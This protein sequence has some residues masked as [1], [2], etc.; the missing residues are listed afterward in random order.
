MY[1][2]INAV[3]LAKEIRA[4]NLRETL[5][6]IARQVF[7]LWKSAL[8]KVAYSVAHQILRNYVTSSELSCAYWM[9]RSS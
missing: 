3:H 1:L 4:D 9:P 8:A 5:A 6:A 7:Y 2:W